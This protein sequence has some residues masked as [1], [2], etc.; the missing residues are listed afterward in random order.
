MSFDTALRASEILL[1]L[2]FLQSSAEHLF[3]LGRGRVL[4]ALRFGLA[5]VLLLGV[6]PGW[7]LLALTL[8]SFAVLHRFDGPYN[9]GSDRMS[10]LVLYCLTLA[11]WLPDGLAELALGYLAAQVTLSYFISGRVKI[12]NPDWRSGQALADVFAF[13]AY[14][15]SSGLRRLAERRRLLW[16]ASWAVILLEILFPLALL[17][18]PALLTALALTFSFH[19]ANAA[20]FGL[21]RFV[22]AWLAAYPSLLWLH[23]KIDGLVWAASV[24]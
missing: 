18:T 9:G 8:H 16:A 20:L 23:G 12:V 6:T 7:T 14:P 10:L 21:N 13:S 5:G 4:F 11:H 15:V 1:A 2:A 22:W 24:S 17:W 3:G 19:L